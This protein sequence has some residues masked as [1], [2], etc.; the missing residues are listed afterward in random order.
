MKKLADSPPW[1]S[2]KK[3]DQGKS[4]IQSQSKNMTK[5]KIKTRKE[6]KKTNKP[7]ADRL[8][9]NKKKTNKFFPFECSVDDEKRKKE[10]GKYDNN[11]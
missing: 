11:F 2:K 9:T 8:L 5:L 1:T 6:Q 3:I 10:K 4:S 7:G